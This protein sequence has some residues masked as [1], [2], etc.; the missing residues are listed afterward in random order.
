MEVE[1][2]WGNN[3]REE[4]D[5]IDALDVLLDRLDTESRAD[6]LPNTVHV[7]VGEAAMMITVG[8]SISHVEFYSQGQAP[9]VVSCFEPDVDDDPVTNMYLGSYTEIERSGYMDYL[10]AREGMRQFIRTGARPTNIRWRYYVGDQST[11]IEPT[12]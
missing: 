5:S 11:I 12:T 9:L 6:D 2:T 3:S 1:V 8:S 10:V 7:E 4:V